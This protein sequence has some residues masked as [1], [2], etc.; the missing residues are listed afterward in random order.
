MEVIKVRIY[1]WL[2]YL[3]QKQ[4]QLL[5]KKKLATAKHLQVKSYSLPLKNALYSD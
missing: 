4:L 5:R 3:K 2:F 1:N